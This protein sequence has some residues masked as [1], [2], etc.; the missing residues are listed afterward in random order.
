[1][2]HLGG[3]DHAVPDRAAPDESGQAAPG[4]GL[5]AGKLRESRSRAFVGRGAELAV[6]RS[7][8][9]GEPGSATV[10]VLVGPGGV[11]KTTLLRRFADEAEALGRT[12]IGV[13]GAAIE[14]APAAFEAA[15]HQA[16]AEPAGVLLIDA[17]E[18]CQGLELW[19]RDTFLPRLPAGVLVVIAGRRPPDPR[20]TADLA[21]SE[22]LRVIE[23]HDFTRAEAVDLLTRR[24]VP[25]PLHGPVIRFAGGHPLALSLAAVVA[26]R[27][28]AAGHWEPGPDVLTALVQELAG[29]VE[30]D[31]HR[32]ALGVLAHAPST[33]EDLLRAVAG[34]RAAELFDWLGAQPFTESHARGLTAHRVVRGVVDQHFRWRDPFGYAAMHRAIVTHLAEHARRSTGS[35]AVTAV[36]ALYQLISPDHTVAPELEDEHTGDFYAAPLAPADAEVVV[37]LARESG[38][39]GA[40]DVVRHWLDRQP[41]AF[42]VFRHSGGGAVAA[43]GAA[44]LLERPDPADLAADPAVATAWR[45]VAGRGP[46]PGERICVSCFLFPVHGRPPG[47]DGLLRFTIAE[48]WLLTE[49]VAWSFVVVAA[50]S[51]LGPLLEVGGFA[52]A[53]EPVR[54]G[55]TTFQLYGHD[56]RE[57]PYDAWISQLSDIAL[58]GPAGRPGTEQGE[59]VLGRA[60]FDAAVRD[61]LRA[62]HNRPAF[63]GNPLLAT[64]LVTAGARGEPEATE[65][66]LRDLLEETVDALREDPRENKLHRALATTY[67]HKVPTQEAAAERLGLPFSTYRRHLTRGLDRVAAALWERRSTA[68]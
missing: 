36:R 3:P 40:V 15:A 20:W 2:R 22:L 4:G 29:A 33:T 62:W 7:A 42:R 9:A 30:S 47:V 39:P 17:F 58:Y 65:Q 48:D 5:L 38:G 61:A 26:S 1:M 67:F 11:G 13:D 21:W 54:L 68:P 46:R 14:P 57:M 44:L 25:E 63:L 51:P 59:P 53:G 32:L 24:G 50:D 64:R 34:E 56:W 23:L 43:S 49:R 37:R 66:R 55:G 12:V 28:G 31:A 52:R 6:L 18:R 19:L 27:A 35:E 16:L 8:L 10:F 60:E 45:T 41:E